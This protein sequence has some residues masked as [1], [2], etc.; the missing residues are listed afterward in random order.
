MGRFKM[1]ATSEVGVNLQSGYNGHLSP[2]G[3]KV[4]VQ[5]TFSLTL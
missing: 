5:Y 3:H 4:E 2:R 1:Q